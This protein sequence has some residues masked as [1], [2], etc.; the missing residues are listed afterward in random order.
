[1]LSQGATPDPKCKLNIYHHY[2]HL[3]IY[4]IASFVPGCLCPLFCYYKWWEDG[5]GA[6]WLI[7]I[8]VWEGRQR[9][10]ITL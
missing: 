6:V 10:G 3:H 2:L 1:M 7:Y 8:R 9:L 4:L 5:I